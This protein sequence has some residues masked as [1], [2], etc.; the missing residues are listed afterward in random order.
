MIQTQII[1]EMVKIYLMGTT[2][3]VIIDK[4]TGVLLE[5]GVKWVSNDAEELYNKYRQL[6]KECIAEIS[7]KDKA[8]K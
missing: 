5:Q 3:Y 4:E 2:P 7:S 1:E 8:L 6:L